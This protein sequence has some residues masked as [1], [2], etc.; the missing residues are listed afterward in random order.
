[1]ALKTLD[2]LEIGQ[3]LAITLQPQDMV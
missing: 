2:K 3:V 1:M